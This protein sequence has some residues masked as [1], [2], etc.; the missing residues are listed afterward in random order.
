MAAFLSLINPISALLDRL[1]PD[2]SAAA[3]AKAQLAQLET[4]GELQGILAQLDVNKQEA[5]SQSVFVAGWRP[6]IGWVCG[7]GLATQFVIAPL[8][9][10]IAALIGHPIVFPS[11]DM[12]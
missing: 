9:T 7:S 3:A 5:A 1:I 10:W 8:V 4:T 11:L 12:G 6:F 2:K